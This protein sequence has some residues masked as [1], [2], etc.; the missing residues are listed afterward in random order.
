MKKRRRGYPVYFNDWEKSR[1]RKEKKSTR[2]KFTNCN[3]QN[4]KLGLL[5]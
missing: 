3:V 4:F 1:K 2:M 5:V